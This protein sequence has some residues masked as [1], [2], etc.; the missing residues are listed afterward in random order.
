M[1]LLGVRDGTSRVVHAKAARL[2]VYEYVY[3]FVT[4]RLCTGCACKDQN[5]KIC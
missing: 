1:N 3:A 5:M 2:P 4:F